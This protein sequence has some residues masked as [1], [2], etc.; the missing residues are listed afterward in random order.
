MPLM[1]TTGDMAVVVALHFGRVDGEERAAAVHGVCCALAL[2]S[3][4]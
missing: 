1:S 2:T 3:P 4:R